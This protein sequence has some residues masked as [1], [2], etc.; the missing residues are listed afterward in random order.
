M[1]ELAP[2]ECP[3]SVTSEPLPP[4]AAMLSRTQCMAATWSLSG[5]AFSS[6]HG[7]NAVRVVGLQWQQ[8]TVRRLTG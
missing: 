8:R 1:T 5:D 2:A 7:S 3:N 4:K 6:E